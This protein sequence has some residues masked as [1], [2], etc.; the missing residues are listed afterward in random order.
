MLINRVS[1]AVAATFSGGP[2]WESNI[3]LPHSATVL[4]TKRPREHPLHILPV[5]TLLNPNNASQSPHPQDPA[6]NAA[7]KTTMTKQGAFL[8]F[9]LAPLP[10][11]ILYKTPITV[12]FTHLPSATLPRYRHQRISDLTMVTSN[13][14]KGKT[15][16]ASAAKETAAAA[17][18]RKAAEKAAEK[19]EKEAAAELAKK[20]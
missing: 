9:A 7:P 2:V 12:N 17:R 3:D 20:E 14:S 16:A 10:P 4:Q 18:T 8:P 19:K 6:H 11:P 1:L 13:S 15:P 5:K